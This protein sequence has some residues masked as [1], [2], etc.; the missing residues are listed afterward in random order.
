MD[1]VSH[2]LRRINPEPEVVNRHTVDSVDLEER[3]VEARQARADENERERGES[4]EEDRRL[5]HDRDIGGNGAHRTAPHVER[6]VE[7][8][9]PPLDR[10]R[11][12]TP[13][14]GREEDRDGDP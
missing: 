3:A 13:E 6:V 5:E 1:G 14:R 7:G 10:E 12:R 11:E 9:R 8:V 2:L 4:T